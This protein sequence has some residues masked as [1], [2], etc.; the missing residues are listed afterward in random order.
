[1]RNLCDIIEDYLIDLLEDTEE[2]VIQR[3]ELASAFRCVPSQITYVLSTRFTLNKGYIVESRRGG[4]GC[5]RIYRIKVPEPVAL[6]DWL[7]NP[8]AV[9]DES[10]AL[11]IVSVLEK[12]GIITSR[13]GSIMKAVLKEEVLDPE[14]RKGK[15]YNEVVDVLNL[16]ARLL[17]SM[18]KGFLSS[19]DDTQ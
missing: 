4:G 17:S 1:M 7:D 16:R 19:I 11:G 9:A 3:G 12:E 18:I 5:I 15:H 13:E 6:L 8:D 2:L 14:G 10:M